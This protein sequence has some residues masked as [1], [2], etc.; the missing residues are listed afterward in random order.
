MTLL[1]WEEKYSVNVSKI[2]SQHKEWI[3]ILNDLDDA[4]TN[5]RGKLAIGESLDRLIEYARS[6]SVLRKN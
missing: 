5:K 3:K 2:D 1:K 6:T 4:I